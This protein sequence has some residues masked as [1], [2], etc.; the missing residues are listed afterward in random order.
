MGKDERLAVL[1]QDHFAYEEERVLDVVIRDM[2]AYM[3][4]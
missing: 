4:S 2:N 1:K 3:K